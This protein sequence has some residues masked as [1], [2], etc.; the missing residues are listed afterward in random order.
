MGLELN[1]TGFKLC[2][3]KN[4]T[5]DTKM[6]GLKSRSLQFKFNFGWK[7]IDSELKLNFQF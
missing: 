5:M 1:V 7:L 6:D 3:L 4:Q 2:G